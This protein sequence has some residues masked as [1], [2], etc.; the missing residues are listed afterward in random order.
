[1]KTT[2]IKLLICGIIL[3]FST[4]CN[5]DIL[6]LTPLN[7]Y[8]EEATFSNPKLIEAYITKHYKLINAGWG[9]EGSSDSRYTLRYVSDE[10]MCNFGSWNNFWDINK[11]GMTP[12]LIGII[13]TWEKYFKNIR[14][15]NILF[16]N[17]KALDTM[18]EE[19]KN[20]LLGEAHFFRAFY[21]MDLVNK[22]GGV[23]ILEQPIELNQTDIPTKRNTYEES[24]NFVVS[25]F[26]KAADLLPLK[27]T[28]AN[29]GRA[30]KGAALALK[31]RMLLY[32]ASP[33]WNTSND[34]TKWQKAADA[35]LEVINL[36][37]YSL[38]SNYGGLFL[39]PLSSEIIFEKLNTAEFGPEFDWT[40]FPNGYGG[41]SSTC[42]L[43][44]M[45]DSYEMADGSMPN[46]NIY[47]T[48]T[49][50]PWE[51]R[52]PRLYASII[53][54]GQTF[55]GREVEFWENPDGKTGGKDSKYGNEGW[56]STKSGY[57]L[58]K[59]TDESIPGFWTTKSKQPWVYSRLAEIYLNYA[60]A[61]FK[62]GDEATAKTYL[63]LIRKRARAGQ[64]VL[65][66]ITA[67]GAQ[68]WEKIQ[69]ER[70]VEL[71]F[72]DHRFFD[73]RRWKIA[74]VT[75][76]KKARGLRI[77]KNANGTKSYTII[78]IQERAFSPQHYLLP[79]P[80][81]EIQKNANL[82]QNPLYK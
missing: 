35:A 36:G 7:S 59:F 53:W 21:Y 22:Y 75:E 76:N 5:D 63:N 24:A 46:P 51:N 39:N 80:R 54:D 18:S 62:L 9:S 50:N 57:T 32:M 40:Q 74:E 33:L 17:A 52:D 64:N 1:M 42:V 55:R 67:S 14:D 4:S 69:N 29:F 2:K 16:K 77:I 10:S 60:E 47:T 13:D 79:I 49:S 81:Y 12:D 65:P 41:Y 30:T 37:Q 44:D 48:A 82:E 28:G 3:I 72:E 58:K 6:N 34:A 66:D 25:E 71:A 78:D 38:D 8:S 11:G 27:H 31:S 68:L 26:Q 45:V 43:Q 15:V 70:K 73:V 61:K 23:P 19:T 56:N 20:L